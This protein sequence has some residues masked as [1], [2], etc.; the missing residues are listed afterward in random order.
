[1]T[2][3][4]IIL[5]FGFHPSGTCDCGGVR[6]E[7]YRKGPFVIYIRKT[8][9]LFKIKRKNEVVIPLKSLNELEKVLQKTFPQPVAG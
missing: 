7:K 4:E 6:N 2:T 1:M 3:E 9:N 8:K 5:S